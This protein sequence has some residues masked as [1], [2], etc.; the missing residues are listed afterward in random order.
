[1]NAFSEEVVISKSCDIKTFSQIIFT[2]NKNVQ[3]FEKEIIKESNCEPETRKAFLSLISTIRGELR[4]EHVSSI[5]TEQG[6][7]QDVN[8]EPSKISLSTLESVIQSKTLLNNGFELSE[9]QFVG[10]EGALTLN[11]QERVKVDCSQCELLGTQNLRLS[12]VDPILNDNRTFWAKSLISKKIKVWKVK[13]DISSLTE[14]NITSQL[15]L[16]EIAVTHPENYLS[17][18]QDLKFF[19]LNKNLRRGDIVKQSDVSPIILIKTGN[20]VKIKIDNKNLN[21]VSTGLANKSA[22]FGDSIE[23]TNLNSKKKIV[24]RVTDYNTVVIDL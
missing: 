2:Q 8:L 20:R 1:M 7:Q 15:T 19:K 3:N 23:L 11:E 13:D 17:E 21:L 18:S 9:I 12:I 24:G 6:I 14:G 22:I 5:L 16:E 10:L 4:A